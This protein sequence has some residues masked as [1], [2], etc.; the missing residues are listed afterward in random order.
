MDPREE[1]ALLE[2][3]LDELIRGIQDLLQS[4]EV[5]TDE[6]QGALAQEIA[7]T[8]DRITALQQEI[9]TSNDNIPAQ[10][11]ISENVML[12]WRLAGGREDAFI[13]YLGNFPDPHFQQLLANP[14]E[15]ERVIEYLNIHN[16][17]N[18]RGVEQ[19]GIPK[20]ELQS[21]NVY[22]MRYDVK[23]KKLLVRFNNGSIYAYSKVPPRIFNLIHNGQAQARTNGRNR[24][25]RWWRGKTP[26][27]GAALN[28]YLKSE[29][30]PYRRLS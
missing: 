30:Y 9:Q 12:I 6:F 14:S 21:S 29:N 18:Q 15:L 2:Q 3:T 10:P 28:Q 1:L 27:A 20:L 17:I 23:N 22:G 8:M 16:P 5:L 19:N 4:G 7:S 11:Q 24:F 25:G 13:D 26:S